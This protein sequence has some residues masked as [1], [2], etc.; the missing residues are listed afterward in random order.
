[1]IESLISR[2]GLTSLRAG[3]PLLSILEAAAQADLRSS[4]DLFQLLNSISLDT[5]TG[6][7]LLRIGQEEGVNQITETPATGTVTITDTSFDKIESRVYQGLPPPIVGSTSLNVADATLF[8]STGSIYLGRGTSNYE[9]ALVYS[10]KVNNS[11][12]WTLTLTNPTTRVHNVGETAIV[13][14]GGN[15]GIGAGTIVKTPQANVT[16]S[17]EFRVLYSV[18]LPD[19]ETDLPGVTVVAEKPGL[20]GNVPAGAISQFATNP[21]AGAT[22][23][24]P[25]PF[26]DGLETEDDD[27][28][29]ER[30]RDARRTRVKGTPLA[31]TSSVI[32]ITSADENKRVSS[33]SLVARL[34]LPSVLVID[35]GTGYEEQFA[36]EAIEVL[37]ESATGGEEYF[38]VQQRP[39]VKAFLISQNSSPF[40]LSAGSEL[41]VRV[42]NTTYNHR[43]DD[44][45]FVAISSASAH[46]VVA[47]I[48]ANEDLGFRAR[49]SASGTRVVLCSK[50]ETNEELQIVDGDT[51]AFRFPTSTAYTLQ[52]YKNDRLLS[53]DGLSAIYPS[54][55]YGDWDAMSGSQTLIL[56]IDGTPSLTYTFTN[57]D[58]IDGNTGFSAVGKNTVAAW[59][60]VVNNKIPGVTA[61]EDEGKLVL[62]SNLGPTSRA[63]IEVEGGTLVSTRMFALGEAV[64]AD[65]DYTFDRN[66]AQIRLETALSAGDRL[67]IGSDATR[68]F[69]ESL[70]IPASSP[71]DS[72]VW[73]TVDGGA[74]RITHGVSSTTPLALTIAG[75]HDWGHRLKIDAGSSAAFLNVLEGDWMVGWDTLWGIDHY[76]VNEVEKDSSGTVLGRYITI[77]RQGANT[78]RGGHRAVK[79]AQVGGDV[80][81]TMIIGGYTRSHTPELGTFVEGVTNVCEFFDTNGGLTRTVAPS[82]TLARAYH[83]ATLLDDDRIIVTGGVSANGEYLDSTEIYD[84]VTETWSAGPDLPEAVCYHTATKLSTGDVLITGGFRIVASANVYSDQACLFEAATDTIDDYTGMTP[85][86]E[87]RA[88]H[89]AVVL[90][91]DTVLIVGGKNATGTLV[92][93]EIYDTTGP[94]TTIK[95]PMNAPRRYFGMVLSGTDVLAVGNHHNEVNRQTYEIYDTVGDTWTLDDIDPAKDVYVESQDAYLNDDGVPLVFGAWY[96]DTTEKVTLVLEHDGTDWQPHDGN[97]LNLDTPTHWEKQWVE[98]SDVNE[99]VG[100][101]GVNSLTK[102]PVAQIERYDSNTG[103]F[104][105]QNVDDAVVSSLTLSSPPG[106]AFI[107][108]LDPLQLI[109]IDS[110]TNYTAP[111]L[112]TYLNERLLGATASVYQT[113]KLRVATNSFGPEGDIGLVASDDLSLTTL[114]LEIGDV[115]SNLVGHMASVESG[116]QEAGTPSFEEI[117]LQGN[118]EQTDADFLDSLVLN[119]TLLTGGQQLVGLRH[120]WSGTPS[121]YHQR[122]GNDL[123]SRIRSGFLSTGVSTNDVSRYDSRNN[124]VGVTLSTWERFYAAAPFSI[125]HEDDLIVQIDNETNKRYSPVLYRKIKPTTG[126]YGVQNDWKDSDAGNISLALTFGLGYNF[127]DFTAYMKARAL[128][129][130]GDATRRVLFRYF[131]H[132]PDGEFARVRFSNPDAASTPAH[133]DVDNLDTKSNIRIKLASGAA[134]TPSIRATTRLAYACTAQTNSVGTLVFAIGFATTDAQRVDV[135]DETRLRLQLPT[136]VTDCGLAPGD[137]IFLNSSN[138]NFADGAYTVVSTDAASGAGGTQDVYVTDLTVG[139]FTAG[140]GIGTVSLDSQGEALFSGVGIVA[141]DYLRIESG[142]D[143]DT[144]WEE[145]T[146]CITTVAAQHLICTSGENTFASG[147][148][149]PAFEIDLIN[150]DE[151][152]SIFAASAQSI[153][154]IAA[155][156]NAAAAVTNSTCPIT[157]TST[158]TGAGTVVQSTPEE[159]LSQDWYELTDGVN[160]ISET[161]S[162]GSTAGDYTLTFKK[163]VT[164]SLGAN[165]DWVNEEVRLVPITTKNLVDWLMTPTISGLYAA[166]TVEASAGGAKVQISSLT[167]GSAG[168]VHV[169]GGLGNGVNVAVVGDAQDTGTKG[170]STVSRS[171]AAGL[172]TGMWVAIDNNNP[173]P[174][175]GIISSSTELVAWG[176][177]GL[178]TLNAPVFTTRVNPVNAKL[179]FEKQG[180]FVAI[181]VPGLDVENFSV[182]SAN[183][184]DSTNIYTLT[185]RIP[186]PFTHCGWQAGDVFSFSGTSIHDVV[187]ADRVNATSTYT[188]TLRLPPGHTSSGYEVGDTFALDS[189][190]AFF[191]SGTYTVTVVGA[192]SGNTQPIEYTLAA[193]SDQTVNF[194]IGR[195]THTSTDFLAGSYTLTE[196]PGTYASGPKTQTIKYTTAAATDVTRVNMGIASKLVQWTNLEEGDYIKIGATAFEAVGWV[197]KQ[198]PVQNQGVFRVVRVQLTSDVDGRGGT[199]WIEN[200]DVVEGVFESRIAGYAYNSI[201]PGDTLSIGSEIWGTA[202]KGL[203]TVEKVG[204]ATAAATAEFDAAASAKFTVSLQDRTPQAMGNPGPLG[205]ASG[206]VQIVEGTPSRLFKK[207]EGICPNQNDGSFFDVRWDTDKQLNQISATAGSVVSALDKLDFSIDLAAGVDGYSYNTGLIAEANRVI[208]GDSSNPSVYPGVAAA[209]AKINIS[210]PSIRRIKLALQLRIKTGASRS[211]IASRVRTAV[212]SYI[213]QIGVGKPVALSSI[214][215]VSSRIPGVVAVTILSPSHTFDN[216]LVPVQPYEKPQILNLDQDI[217]ITF[218]GG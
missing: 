151:N 81:L 95:A 30:I 27:S 53:K 205:T 114:Q 25:L 124:I 168:T 184:V 55:L 31:I 153:T 15:R 39:V 158:G 38:Q 169:Q 71:A 155:I 105:W 103:V 36:G 194:P 24:N 160:W 167:P 20:V 128:A 10:A 127:N 182:A 217:R 66:T 82:M 148:V 83:T 52:L 207:I 186:D 216:D 106:L 195:V 107:R 92:S 67:S 100:A 28:Y 11:T 134:R 75:V 199:V 190:N 88:Q 143:V 7:A 121:A 86:D 104:D 165:S 166:A 91:D 150:S 51:E 57:Q 163:A 139:D 161:T 159:L 21:F 187:A 211:D 110:G 132:G 135:D 201:V 19:G 47:S 111:S 210:G 72:K 133:V 202:N 177:D 69:L 142:T 22:V 97:P 141:G 154:A 70:T 84:P 171:G 12:H 45:D 79:M 140:A 145:F 2:Q 180:N 33:A 129:F 117:L 162:P 37:A 63:A 183:R 9:G 209:R 54:N 122:Y 123:N 76:R 32:G 14:Q 94:T 64:G 60:I 6:L 80:S 115:V 29:R 197:D 50:G 87:P 8:P 196:D 96:E 175:S 49:T 149:N 125:S 90:A 65:K 93:A 214:E 13:A 61:T 218:A 156:V 26:S 23:T 16:S 144:N 89:R 172:A 62:T 68:S 208:Y 192:V 101:G 40:L 176:V 74:T 138:V 173:L 77:E 200:P 215:A 78:A 174:K 98:L 170:L 43:F 120:H 35:D 17:V 146:Y 203:W 191:A 18:T 152:L 136:A 1:M 206:L 56:S 130:S 44:T 85:L 126:V 73:F 181:S 178:V 4:N 198:V 188:L 58:F 108:T 59:V 213:N 179:N 116:N 102:K 48:N 189:N 193:G 185:L 118:G 5:S 204:V 34:G 42:G 157:M 46:E 212:A 131:R 41:T 147:A 164:A 119:S 109:R 112:V 137:V 3:S 99:F 113:S